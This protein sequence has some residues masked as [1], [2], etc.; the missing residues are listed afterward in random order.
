MQGDW[1]KNYSR[2]KNNRSHIR[3][4]LSL[5]NFDFHHGFVHTKQLY[6]Y[7]LFCPTNF[8]VRKIKWTS[9]AISFRAYLCSS[10]SRSAYSHMQQARGPPGTVPV[11]QLLVATWGILKNLNLSA[12]I[13]AYSTWSA[14]GVLIWNCLAFCLLS[15]SLLFII[16]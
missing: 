1:L 3:L 7:C 13:M 12:S 15:E 16:H 4:H 10:E 11:T 9:L 8:L 5:E 2:K 14:V 6:W